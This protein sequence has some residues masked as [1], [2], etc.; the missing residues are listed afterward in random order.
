MDS[1]CTVRDLITALFP[2][3]AVDWRGPIDEKIWMCKQ[4]G[5]SSNTT[6]DPSLGTKANT[7]KVVE[8]T[9]FKSWS[10]MDVLDLPRWKRRE[11]VQSSSLDTNQSHESMTLLG[12]ME[13]ILREVRLFQLFR[14]TGFKTDSCMHTIFKLTSV[15]MDV[16]DHGRNH[17]TMPKTVSI[18]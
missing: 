12:G 11:I 5:D 16:I 17:H 6:T 18:V 2:H 4:L 14:W 7:G 10:L 8:S 13:A 9:S 1:L 15:S 3:S